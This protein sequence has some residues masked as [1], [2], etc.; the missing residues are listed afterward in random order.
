MLNKISLA[1]QQILLERGS[2]AEEVVLG[3]EQR[4]QVRVDR[5]ETGVDARRERGQ[6]RTAGEH[7]EE[8]RREKG[9]QAGTERERKNRTRDRLTK[10]KKTIAQ[11]KKRTGLMRAAR[12]CSALGGIR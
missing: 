4:E 5:R 7:C 6:V 3:G 8:G 1:E 2:M 11:Q 12:A 10:K 9:R